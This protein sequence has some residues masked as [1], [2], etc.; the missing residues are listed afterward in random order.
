MTAQTDWVVVVGDKFSAFGALQGA[1]PVSQLAASFDRA[2]SNDELPNRVIIGQGVSES[3]LAYLEARAT[4]RGAS[5]VF[6]GER[7]VSDRA[8]KH[9]SHK[10]QRRNVLITR[11]ERT[12]SGLFVMQLSIDDDCEIMSDHVTGH[13]IQGMV[14]IEAARQA[15]LAVTE[16][17]LLDGAQARYFVIDHFNVAFRKFVFPVRTDIEFELSESDDSRTDRLRAAAVIRFTHCGE[18]ACVVDVSYTAIDDQRLRP[19][20]EQMAL[21][22]LQHALHSGREEAA[23]VP[24][25]QAALDGAEARA[26]AA[27]N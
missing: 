7:R 8:G 13:H 19:K 12:G 24:L 14:L 21:S 22:A 18:L 3:W 17:F 5:V 1:T 10:H 25:I 20:E 11:P 23:A 2:A 15:F 4:E 16:R 6:I 9:L 26:V 27:L